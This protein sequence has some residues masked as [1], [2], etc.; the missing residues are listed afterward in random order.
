MK[1]QL[2]LAKL[3]AVDVSKVHKS[4]RIII[5]GKRFSR[6][7]NRICHIV[8]TNEDTP[9]LV[10][11]FCMHEDEKIVYAVVNPIRIIHSAQERSLSCG[12][13]LISVEVEETVKLICVDSFKENLF[14]IDINDLCGKKYIVRMPN[15]HGH[16][17]F[18]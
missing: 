13:H 11:Y 5:N 12:K 8:L 4:S 15:R 2:I 17:V 3:D 18:K 6:M 9:I 1:L 7:K 10:K 14:F 16:S